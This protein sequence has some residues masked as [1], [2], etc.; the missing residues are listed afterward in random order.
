MG[1]AGAHCASCLANKMCA[2][3]RSCKEWWL[4]LRHC[5]F[6]VWL[7]RRREGAAL[8]TVAI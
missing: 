3:N 6:R 1:R 4:R 2:S 7:T 5:V 8:V